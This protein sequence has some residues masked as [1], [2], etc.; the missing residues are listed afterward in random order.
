MAFPRNFAWGCATASYQIEG[1]AFEDGRGLS[2]WDLFSHE[3]GRTAGGD[4]GD[5]AC[6]HYHR[7]PE[8]V[9]LM[10]GIRLNAYRFSVAWPRILPEGKGK[11][12]PRGLGFY[13]RLVDG[14][15]EEGIQPWITLGPAPRAASPRRLAQPRYLRLVC[16]VHRHRCRCPFG[17]G[18][19]LDDVE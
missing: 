2:I 3:P 18:C 11:V 19:P 10:A 1:A 17:P 4:S 5:V 6:D 9:A 13:D 16:R 7:W 15:L 14:L 12:E 8:D